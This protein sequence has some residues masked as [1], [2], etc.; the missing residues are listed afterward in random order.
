MLVESGTAKKVFFNEG[1]VVFREG[2]PGDAAFIVESGAVGIR[3]IVEGEEVELAT[4][5]AGELFGE[6]AIL[7]GSPRMANAVAKEDSVLIKVPNKG[8]EQRMQK[9]DPFFR[10]LIK[11]LINNL[12]GVHKTYM[13]RARSVDDYLNAIAFHSEGFRLYLAS[14]SGVAEAEEGIARLDELDA[15]TAALRELFQEH[16]D[17]R[18][19][20]LTDADLSRSAPPRE[21]PDDD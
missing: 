1:D 17:R 10:A 2:E 12:R 6:M 9:I 19:S 20:A 8:L 13:R 18:H 4:L 11:I 16:E 14:R 21:T 5:Q 7:D 15:A 3:K